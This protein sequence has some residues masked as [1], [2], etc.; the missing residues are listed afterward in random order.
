MAERDALTAYRGMWS[1]FVEAAKT[2][3]AEAPQLREY[4]SDQALSL[5]VSGLLT[6]HAQG[7]I[8][9]G[10]LAVNPKA[11][12]VKPEQSPTEVTVLDCVDST[13]WLE[14]KSSGELWDDEPGSKHRTTATV[15]RSDDTWKVSSFIL[16][17]SGT[18]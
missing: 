13:K 3:D 10:D 6:D 12:E 5:I 8:T 16:E 2:S 15:K 17:E 4:A 1:A 14:Y 18:C 11:T 7:K 9:K